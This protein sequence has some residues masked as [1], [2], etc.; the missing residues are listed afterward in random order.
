[1]GHA[2]VRGPEFDVAVVGGGPVGLITALALARVGANAVVLAAPHR[3]AGVADDTRT[4]ALFHGSIALLR[5]LGVWPGLAPHCAPLAAMRMIDDTGGLLRAPEVV[6]V[7]REM[8]LSEFG[9]NV[10]QA[11]LMR[12]LSLHAAAHPGV[13]MIATAGVQAV[14]H[15][16]GTVE[17]ATSE[18]TRVSARLV[19]ACDGRRSICREA[20]GISCEET[21]YDQV[22]VT[23]AFDHMRPHGGVSTELHRR[24]GPCTVV[25]LP[26]A[27]SSLVWV[28]RPEVARRLAAMPEADFRRR[29]GDSLQGLLGGIGE[30]APRATFQLARIAASTLAARRTVLVGEAG[31]VLPPIGAQGLNLSLRDAATLADIVGDR[32]AAGGNPGDGVVLDAYDR[33]RRTD[34]AT[35]SAAIHAMNTSLLSELLPVHLARGAGLHVAAAIGPVRRAMM[36]LGME[37]AALLPRLMRGE[38]GAQPPAA[39]AARASVA[40]TAGRP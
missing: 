11:A 17:L 30:I 13:S 4:A 15:G 34:V 19:A 28:E 40:E 23:T 1:M 21:A 18:G 3:P 31:H 14:T 37:P 25:P 35:R 2:T 20:A 16:D 26:G 8:G 7:A 9:W 24:A 29:L 33:Q 32:L 36:R 27:R 5:A 10:P 6:F 22:A 38:T 39:T 12:E